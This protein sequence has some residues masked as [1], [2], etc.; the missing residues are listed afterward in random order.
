[1]RENR[2]ITGLLTII[3]VFVVGVILYLLRT[4]LLPFVIALLL[5]NLFIPVVR[6]LRSKKVPT[7]VALFVVLLSVSAVLFLLSLILYSSFESFAIELPKYRARFVSV[8]VSALDHFAIMARDFGITDLPELDPVQMINLEAVTSAITS[9]IGSFV[10]VITYTF[11]VVLFML[12]MLAESADMGDRIRRAFPGQQADRISTMLLNIDGQVRQYLLTKTLI[13]LG[14][15]LLTTVVLWILG[16]DFALLFGFLAFLLNFIPNVG[17][18]IAS[19]LPFVLALLQFET[20]TVPLLV[21]ILLGGVQMLMGNVM[22]PRLMAFSLNL[23]ALLVLVSLIFWGWLWG[24]L[25]MVLA[26]PLTATVKIIFENVDNLKPFAV[27]M[28]GRA[29]TP[30]GH[31]SLAAPSHSAFPSEESTGDLV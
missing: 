31:S 20:L 27:L 2:L 19:L 11:L 28:S 4:V 14:T 25:G 17:S 18:M 29:E 12:F 5:S 30:V 16:V 9:G 24:I 8:M 3:A 6:W 10:S 1:M 26:V 21:L 13:S 23:S 7:I 15:G 22:E